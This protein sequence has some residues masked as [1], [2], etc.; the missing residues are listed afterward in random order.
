MFRIT[1]P[2]RQAIRQTTNIAGLH[3]HPD[4]IPALASTYEKTLKLLETIPPSSVYRQGTEAL[5]QRK[6]DIVK[7]SN[8]DAF[9]AEKDLDEGLI[10]QVIQV[11]EDELSLVTKMIEWKAWE[12]LEERAPPGQWQYF[13]HNPVSDFS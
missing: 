6:L 10:E 7:A 3:P 13:E 11:A 1:R 2:L 5:T 4:P 8:G 12:P 9:K